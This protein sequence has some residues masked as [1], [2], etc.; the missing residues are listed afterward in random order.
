MKANTKSV[1]VMMIAVT[2]AVAY[3]RLDR[4]LLLHLG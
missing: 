1:L 4:R 2:L 3:P